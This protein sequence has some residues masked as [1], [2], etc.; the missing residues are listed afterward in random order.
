MKIRLPRSD[1]LEAAQR[2]SLH[3]EKLDAEKVVIHLDVARLAAMLADVSTNA[4][5]AQ[6][7]LGTSGNSESHQDHRRLLRNIEAILFSLQEFGVRV[8]DHTGETYDY[9]QALKVAAAQPTD[10]IQREVVTE[11]IRPSVFWH[12]VM[13]Q[14]GEVVIATPK[15]EEA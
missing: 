13:I 11:T 1:E 8:K 2:E 4:W 12:E 3:I 9:G 10:G 6:T 15:G 7:R 14:R 5:K